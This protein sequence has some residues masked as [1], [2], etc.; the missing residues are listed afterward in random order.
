MKRYTKSATETI[1]RRYDR[2]SFFFDL[3]EWPVELLRFS[4]WRSR[5]RNALDGPQALE[6]GV[7]TGK[8]MKY[9]PLTLFDG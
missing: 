4:R 5:L 2:L 7:G 3:M 9:Y 8:N 6:V 1:R